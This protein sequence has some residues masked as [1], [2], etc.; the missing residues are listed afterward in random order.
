MDYSCLPGTD[1]G[2]DYNTTLPSI[3]LISSISLFDNATSRKKSLSKTF[4]VP[5]LT[6][7][8]E[9]ESS[10]PSRGLE[11]LDVMRQRSGTGISSCPPSLQTSNEGSLERT[12]QQMEPTETQEEARYL[13]APLA[14]LP[15]TNQQTVLVFRNGTEDLTEAQSEETSSSDNCSNDDD[16][17]GAEALAMQS[18]GK[19]LILSDLD[20]HLHSSAVDT[21]FEM[22]SV[23]PDGDVD[24]GD[25]DVEQLSEFGSSMYISLEKATKDSSVTKVVQPTCHT[26]EQHGKSRAGSYVTLINGTR[27][28]E[29]QDKPKGSAFLQ[30]ASTGHGENGVSS[31][32][33]QA[34]PLPSPIVNIA[35]TSEVTQTT[36]HQNVKEMVDSPYQSHST[37]RQSQQQKF[38]NE[39]VAQFSSSNDLPEGIEHSDDEDSGLITTSCTSPDEF[40]A[41]FTSNC[42]TKETESFSLELLSEIDN[43]SLEEGF[44][45][46]ITDLQEESDINSA[47]FCGNAELSLGKCF[48]DDTL[49]LYANNIPDQSCEDKDNIPLDSKFHEDTELEG[50]EGLEGFS[51]VMAYNQEEDENKQE[52]RTRTLTKRGISGHGLEFPA[53][54]DSLA[55]VTESACFL[56]PEMMETN[57][58]EE[59]EDEDAEDTEN[60][61]TSLHPG[62][63]EN[64][65]LMFDQAQEHLEMKEFTL[66]NLSKEQDKPS[67]HL[68]FKEDHFVGQ[69]GETG[70]EDTCSLNDDQEA[71]GGFEENV[72]ESHDYKKESDLK[73]IPNFYKFTKINF[74][75]S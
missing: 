30:L 6:S 42:V 39:L 25:E 1:G 13:P 34:T 22:F 51:C 9:Y 58:E 50:L 48:R 11:N 14:A 43:C 69:I 61:D 68:D 29:P 66:N 75:A 71:G 15:R 52:D 73:G 55:P 72:S 64:T 33:V 10:L 46:L 7:E 44:S 2:E 57:S 62:L 27:G 63:F 36:E 41:S 45:P 20:E 35:A 5:G 70:I 38:T 31:S 28:S 12:G 18:L 60:E 59:S 32:P 49:G 67:E 74:Q 17:A 54:A 37:A 56:L 24:Q 65:I 26:E 4:S 47:D 8:N 53:L 21:E 23:I 40:L 19:H 3:S 16:T